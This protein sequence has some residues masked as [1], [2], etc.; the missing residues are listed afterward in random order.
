MTAVAPLGETPRPNG[1]GSPPDDQGLALSEAMPKA[2][3]CAIDGNRQD[4]GCL[5]ALPPQCP[6]LIE[7]VPKLNQT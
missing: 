5:T 6:T 4:G 2:L 1:K 3:R 7:L